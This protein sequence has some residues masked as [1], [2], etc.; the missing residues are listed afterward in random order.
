MGLTQQHC[1]LF[2]SL[3]RNL[4]VLEKHTKESGQQQ[5]INKVI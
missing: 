2:K 1:D 5:Q 3:N 4:C